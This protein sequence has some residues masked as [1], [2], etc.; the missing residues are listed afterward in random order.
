MVTHDGHLIQ[1]PLNLDAASHQQAQGDDFAL[2]ITI[3]F[4]QVLGRLLR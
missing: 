4:G 1:G 2:T 3:R